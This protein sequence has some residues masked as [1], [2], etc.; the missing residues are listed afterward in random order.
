[1]TLTKAYLLVFG[2]FVW[3]IGSVASLALLNIPE[4]SLLP[5]FLV[6]VGVFAVLY[7]AGVSIWAAAKGHHFLWGAVPNILGPVIV[8]MI[9]AR[10]DSSIAV[11][12][13]LVMP[14]P[15]LLLVL[16]LPNL[17][18]A[19][20]EVAE[21]N[22]GPGGEWELKNL[23]RRVAL[24]EQ[25]T[26]SPAAAQA[27]RQR[28]ETTGNTVLQYHARTLTLLK[29]YCDATPSEIFRQRA[30]TLLTQARAIELGEVGRA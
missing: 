7:L 20:A 23:A 30:E 8:G 18:N 2:S 19:P 9:A 28:I 14:L 5:S 13:V 21:K 29:D 1:M 15:G 25:L 16:F 17:S 12:G 10:F 24:L 6:S 22:S 11:W 26:Q 27:A 4:T 3:L